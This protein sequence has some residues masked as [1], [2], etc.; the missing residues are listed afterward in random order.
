MLFALGCDL[1]PLGGNKSKLDPLFE[2]GKHI[3]SQP[4]TIGAIPNY[5]M[6][7]NE[8][9]TIPFTIGDADTFMM[10]S[11]IF[12]KG[13]SSNQT[14]I[15]ST[16]LLVGGLFPNC[17]LQISPKSFQFGVSTIKVEVYDFWTKADSSFQLTVLHVL[18]PGV[19]S[20]I[21]AEGGDKKIDVTWG[22]AAYMTGTSAKYSL[23]YRPT[24]S[25]AF[26]QISNV[27][28]P[29]TIT[30][31]TNGVMYDIYVRA[32]NSIGFR[33]SQTV[34]AQ[35]GKYRVLG[36]EFVPSSQQYGNTPGTNT[37]VQVT[38]S[39]L[40]AHEVVADAN[41]PALTYSLAEVPADG[42]VVVGSAKPSSLTSPSGK[43]KVYINSQS[44]ILSG[45]AR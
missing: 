45:D 29:Y 16:G 18:K 39:T 17:T 11:L 24:G 19:F 40:V 27:H 20:I 42:H 9:T 3:Q 31:L 2:P 37:N 6:D 26:S 25:A 5:V 14:L 34:Q 36:S 15:D 44:N 32:Q 28:S 10:C 4:P 1:N 35:P 43:Y 12:V 30:G 21:D 38:S 23:F 8:V 33:D 41:Y 7:E 22:A 13:Y